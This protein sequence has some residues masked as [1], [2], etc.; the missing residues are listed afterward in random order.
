MLSVFVLG[1]LKAEDQ[2]IRRLIMAIFNIKWKST[3]NRCDINLYWCINR[4]PVSTEILTVLHHIVTAIAAE[5]ENSYWNQ[6]LSWVHIMQN[7]MWPAF[8]VLSH[9]PTGL[10][11]LQ[12]CIYSF[13]LHFFSFSFLFFSSFKCRCFWFWYYMLRSLTWRLAISEVWWSWGRP[14][15]D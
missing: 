14:V 15:V 1:E 5:N 12:V 6:M 9:I 7:H 4:R 2:S 8:T 13:F 3:L 10:H 11:A